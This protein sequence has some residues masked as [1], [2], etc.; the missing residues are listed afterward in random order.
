ML[1]YV[2]AAAPLKGNARR[3]RTAP[4]CPAPC[5]VPIGACPALTIRVRLQPR[6]E[7]HS[8]PTEE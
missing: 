1:A 4:P 3:L 2:G 7:E 8:L 5:S 6:Y